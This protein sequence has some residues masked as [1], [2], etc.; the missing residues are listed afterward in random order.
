MLLQYRDQPA[1]GG[2]TVLLPFPHSQPVSLTPPLCLEQTARGEFLLLQ[3]TLQ[4]SKC[5]DP[6]FVA[7]LY[8]S[9][10]SA[11]GFAMRRWALWD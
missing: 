8:P 7:E 5:R 4:L 1:G 10:F 9:P 11:R 3:V 6:D 2:D